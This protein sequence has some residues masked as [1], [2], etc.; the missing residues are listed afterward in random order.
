LSIP[1]LLTIDIT[2][3]NYSL[4]GTVK[5]LMEMYNEKKERLKKIKYLLNIDSSSEVNTSNIAV[6][7]DGCDKG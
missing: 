5:K 7:Y 4:Y 3:I 1:D 6:D 2:Q